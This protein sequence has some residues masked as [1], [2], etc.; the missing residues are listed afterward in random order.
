M[1]KRQFLVPLLLMGV[2]ASCSPPEEANESEMM[3][4]AVFNGTTVPAGSARDSMIQS[5]TNSGGWTCSGT[6]LTNNFV[7]TASHCRGVTDTTPITVTYGTACTTDANCGG[8]G[9]CIVNAN[10]SFCGASVVQ[11]YNNPQRATNNQVDLWR[12]SNPIAAASDPGGRFNIAQPVWFG[13]KSSVLNQS[14]TTLGRNICNSTTPFGT[15]LQGGFKVARVDTTWSV[16]LDSVNGSG[17]VSGDSG[18]PTYLKSSLTNNGSMLLG[19]TVQASS[20]C[21]ANNVG[22][23]HVASE[24]QAWFDDALFDAPKLLQPSEGLSMAM[25]SSGAF[26]AFKTGSGIYSRTCSAEPCDS[27]GIWSGAEAVFSDGSAEPTVVRDSISHTVFSKR[28]G[29][30]QVWGRTKTYGTW[31]SPFSI[32]GNC[33]SAPQAYSRPNSG[34]LPTVDIV[35]LNNGALNHQY[36]LGSNGSYSGF[37]S[38]GAPPPGIKAGSTPAVVATDASTTYMFVVGN[39]GSAWMLK[40]VS[41]QGFGSWTSLGGGGIRSIAAASYDPT[42]LD[43]FVITTDGGM[44]HKA[45]DNSV[46]FPNWIRLKGGWTDAKAWAAAYSGHKARMNVGGHQGGWAHV[47][48]YSDF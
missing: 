26:M 9:R 19:P 30:N 40:G 1:L 41:G 2:S 34:F 25:N 42:R 45:A 31:S 4:S 35:C 20:V 29:S 21:Q 13:A 12:L 22:S 28:S 32:G 17:L 47:A 36:R 27:R 11:R 8:R 6:L 43:V 3:T 16:L 24:V 18:G 5:T 48:R 33:T 44:Y 23:P 7:L 38:V 46:W 10:G 37:Y 14:V 39:D 15:L